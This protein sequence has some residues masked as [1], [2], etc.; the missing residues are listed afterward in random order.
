MLTASAVRRSILTRRRCPRYALL[1][2]KDIDLYDLS[3]LFTCI[4]PLLT[5]FLRQT[6]ER[7]A[8]HLILEQ[9]HE[10]GMA[11]LPSYTLVTC[12][13]SMRYGLLHALS[14]QQCLAYDSSR[15]EH[16][17]SCRRKSREIF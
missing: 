5:Q 4:E 16:A 15:I 14:Y 3:L 9:A 10:I 1:T 7:K 11:D 6:V 12:C 8:I 13:L 2:G 17:A